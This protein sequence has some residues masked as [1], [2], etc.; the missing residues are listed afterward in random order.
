MGHV[1]DVNAAVLA[2]TAGL[3]VVPWPRRA[4]KQDEL[5]RVRDRLDLDWAGDRCGSAAGGLD[6][7][8]GR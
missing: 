2:V 5:I 6:G 4:P 7:A 3:D 1:F 8:P